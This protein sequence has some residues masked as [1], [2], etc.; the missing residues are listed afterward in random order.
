MIHEPIAAAAQSHSPLACRA[1]LTVA[2]DA[3]VA[4][5]PHANSAPAGR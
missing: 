1:R 4:A 5:A 2:D 3:P